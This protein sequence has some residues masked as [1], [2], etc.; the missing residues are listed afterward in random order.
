MSVPEF[1]CVSQVGECVRNDD[2]ESLP[3]SIRSPNALPDGCR[4]GLVVRNM[5][6]GTLQFLKMLH[7]KDKIAPNAVQYYCGGTPYAFV[8]RPRPWALKTNN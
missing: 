5:E 2:T 6:D 7:F 3:A 4:L 1:G 8:F